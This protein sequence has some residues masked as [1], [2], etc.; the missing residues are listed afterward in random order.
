MRKPPI[1]IA[2]KYIRDLQRHQEVADAILRYVAADEP[3]PAEW[4]DEFNDYIK[5]KGAVTDGG[6]VDNA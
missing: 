3:I 1:G 6:G 5:P 2:P 4:V